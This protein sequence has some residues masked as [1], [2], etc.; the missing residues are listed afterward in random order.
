MFVVGGEDDAACDAGAV[1]C[2]DDSSLVNF[3]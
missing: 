2:D 1:V 3:V